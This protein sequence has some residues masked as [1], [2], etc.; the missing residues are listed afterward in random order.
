M[1]TTSLENKNK[2]C[3]SHNNIYRGK[4]RRWCALGV[5]GLMFLMGLSMVTDAGNYLVFLVIGAL[6]GLPK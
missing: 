5:C 3:Q 4:N 6:E 2:L 1:S